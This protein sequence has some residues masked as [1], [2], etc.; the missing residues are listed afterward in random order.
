MAENE[1]GPLSRAHKKLVET[2]QRWA[3]EGRLLTGRAAHP[4][5]ERTGFWK[6]RGYHDRGDPWKEERYG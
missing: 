2:K 4:E 6:E 3:R 5:E 1:E